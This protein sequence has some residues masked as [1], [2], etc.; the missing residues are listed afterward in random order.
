MITF[1][2]VTITYQAADVLQP[3]L[4][5]VAMQDYEDLEHIIVDGASKDDTMRLVEAHKE[6]LMRLHDEG[7][8]VKVLSE[9]D[10]GL[11]Y[12]MNKGLKMCTGDYVC[13]LNAGDRLP[14]PDTL[15]RIAA[16]AEGA[17]DG[18]MPAVLY[19]DTDIVDA[20]GNNL[21]HRH[22][23]PPDELSW[24]SFNNGMLVCHQAFY[25]RVDIAQQV[26]YDTSLRLSSDVDWCIRIMRLAEEKGLRLRRVPAVIAHYLQAGQ[27]T[28]HHQRSL[29][30]R[31]VV[32]QRH[33]G[34]F[35]TIFRHLSFIPRALW[36]NVKKI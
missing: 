30:E 7:R 36:R 33:Y 28:K 22:L 23:S 34:L 11:Y 13:F 27:S 21:G 9:P 10:K 1:S 25:A 17:A 18:Q 5:S 20:E 12:A 29:W 8:R 15:S 24:R 14:D 31:F 3:T 6:H 2:I 26:P 16:T 32:M 19:G 4:D 35:P